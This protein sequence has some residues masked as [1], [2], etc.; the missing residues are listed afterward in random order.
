MTVRYQL[1]PLA[2]LVLAACSHGRQA[3]VPMLAPAPRALLGRTVRV[4]PKVDMRGYWGRTQLGREL[5]RALKLEM[6]GALVRAGYGIDDR[7]PVLEA[8]L[9]AEVS[10]STNNLE[11]RTVLEILHGGRVVDRVEVMTPIAGTYLKAELYPEFAAVRLTNAMSASAPLL[12]LKLDNPLPK[13][14]PL[15]LPAD[16][17]TVVAAFD[18]LDPAEQLDPDARDQLS[19]YVTVRVTQAMGVRIV[20]RAQLR[21]RLLQA[22]KE[23]YQACVDQECQ[24]ELGKALA[25]EKILAPKLIRLGETCVLTATLFDLRTE[26]AE[27]AASVKTKCGKDALLSGVDALVESLKKPAT[28][29]AEQG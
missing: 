16:R 11:S 26:T 27:T 20:P 28:S 29:P 19:E 1:C 10:G 7:D 17:G 25:A 24:I 5:S 4:D 14:P 22:K 18:V 13:P 15:P 21:E 23:S 3:S 6:D 2:M 9:S 12:A 8:R